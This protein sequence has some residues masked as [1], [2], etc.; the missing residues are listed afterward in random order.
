MRNFA[1]SS[2]DNKFLNFFLRNKQECSFFYL[3]TKKKPLSIFDCCYLNNICI[4]SKCYSCGLFHKFYWSIC[5]FSCFQKEAWQKHI[6]KFRILKKLILVAMDLI[7]SSFSCFC[8]PFCWR[9][10]R[11]MCGVMF[12]CEVLPTVGDPVSSVRVAGEANCKK[13]EGTFWLFWGFALSEI[14]VSYKLSIPRHGNKILRSETSFGKILIFS[15][16]SH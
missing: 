16:D 3:V 14:L 1:F 2:F 15:N 11:K 4:V 6:L 10:Q 9:I 12:L 13:W 5:S 8:S 7:W